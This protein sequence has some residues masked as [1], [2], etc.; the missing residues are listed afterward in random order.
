LSSKIESFHFFSR[1]GTILPWKETSMPPPWTVGELR[2]S[3][4][5]SLPVKGE[6]R[7]NLVRRLRAGSDPFPGLVGYTDTVQPEV[8]HALLARH[9]LL[10]L[11]RRG[12]AK[13]RLLRQLVHLLDEALPIVAGSEVRDDPFAPLSAYARDRLAREGDD[14]PIEWLGPEQRYVEKLATPDVTVADLVGDLDLIKHAGGLTLADERVVHYGLLPRSNR[15]LFCLNEL[16]DLAPRVQVALFNVLQERDVQIRGFPVRLPLDICL[17]FSANPEDYT[18]RGRIVTPL[19]DR[20][21]SVVRTHYPR[22]RAE[23]LAILRTEAWRDRGTLPIVVPSFLDEVVEEAVRQARASPALDPRSGVSVRLSIACA[24]ALVSSAERRALILGEAAAVP[25]CCDLAALAAAARGKLELALDE[26]A[27][28]DVVW[29]GLLDS[30]LRIVFLE[31]F[32]PLA[33]QAVT[34]WFGPGRRFEAGA[35]VPLGHYLEQLRLIAPLAEQAERLARQTAA[36]AVAAE[37]LLASAAEFIL[38]GLVQTRH[39]SRTP[40]AYGPR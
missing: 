21:G 6:L 19:K 20:L 12:Q 3:G 7:R 9:D 14:T 22:T 15:G 36:P 33:L 17:A 2:A 39:L 16:P 5:Q 40:T 35:A 13:T 1:R 24:E 18:T 25:R 10:L 27:D 30:A 28:E 31:Y 34:A 38:E 23:G 29:G 8:V 37:G 26:D 11:G 32:D 4:Y